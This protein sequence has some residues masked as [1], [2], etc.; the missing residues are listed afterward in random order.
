M[1]NKHL[2]SNLGYLN[3]SEAAVWYNL[4][5][6]LIVELI[7]LLPCKVE[8]IGLLLSG[9]GLLSFLRAELGNEV[10]RIVIVV[11]DL[12]SHSIVELSQVNSFVVW[13]WLIPQLRVVLFDLGDLLLELV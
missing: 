6:S 9:R 4:P 5:S 11:A 13:D 12:Q 3:R 10:I 8:V 2:E 7:K 1:F